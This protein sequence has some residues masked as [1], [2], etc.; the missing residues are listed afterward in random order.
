MASL[1]RAV[2]GLNSFGGLIWP[3]RSRQALPI[4]LLIVGGTLDLITPPLDEQLLLLA[5]LA[6]HPYSRVVVVEGASHFS[7]IRVESQAGSVQGDDLFQLGEELV[8][9]NPLT[10]QTVIVQEMIQFLEQL[11][12]NSPP[13]AAG[14]FDGG[15]NRWHRLNRDEADRLIGDL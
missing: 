15:T 10:V 14:H 5:G 11:E 2:V 12:S 4:P 8:G 6:E 1:P 13:A 7:P 9:V 3:H